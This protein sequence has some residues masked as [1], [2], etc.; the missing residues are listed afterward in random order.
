[1]ATQVVG[2]DN[3]VLL[4]MD[5]Q[6]DL[7]DPDGKAAP[8][9]I[10]KV[11]RDEGTIERIAALLGEARDRG[12]PV[13]HIA[14]DMSVIGSPDELAPTGHFYEGLRALWPLVEKGTP[15]Y[16]FIPELA[17]RPGEE[18][19]DK[20]GVSAFSR[21]RLESVLASLGRRHLVLT[22]VVTEMVVEATARE[23]TD[24]GYGVHV[25]ADCTNSP[26]KDHHESS[27]RNCI[28][29]VARVTDSQ[30]IAGEWAGN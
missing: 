5:C 13:V 2:R 29:L 28:D 19:V 11:A 20:A 15:G 27:L 18:V 4:V 23:A 22:G 14:I 16:E 1:M 3:S 30:A 8:F 12:V 6:R 26:N 24:K 9:G 7:L 10:W 17:P 25:P 21:S